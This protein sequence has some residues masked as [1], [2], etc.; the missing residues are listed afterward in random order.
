MKKSKVVISILLILIIVI[1]RLRYNYINKQYPQVIEEIYSI[2]EKIDYRGVELSVEEVRIIEHEEIVDM[3]LQ[4]SKFYLE[5]KRKA[6]VAI[7]TFKNNS[8]KLVSIESDYFEATT[9]DWHN[10]LNYEMFSVLNGGDKSPYVE[11]NSKEEITLQL[12]Y[13]MFDFQFKENTWD[14]IRELQFRLVVD[15]YPIKKSVNLK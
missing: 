4:E 9:I 15:V 3:N 12:P 1:L 8:D 14:K 10:G 11:L 7:V 13:E 5:D 2:G 6:I